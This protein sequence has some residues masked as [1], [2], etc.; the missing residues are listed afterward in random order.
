MLTSLPSEFA[1]KA[2]DKDPLK[3]PKW[4]CY[5]KWLSELNVRST[6]FKGD[7]EGYYYPNTKSDATYDSNGKRIISLDDFYEYYTNYINPQPTQKQITMTKKDLT[8]GMLVEFRN[9]DVGMILNDV[10]T[11]QG[12]DYITDV[13]SLKDDLTHENSSPGRSNSWDVMKVSRPLTGNDLADVANWNKRELNNHVKWV[14]P[15]DVKEMTV[16]EISAALGYEVKIV[17]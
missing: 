3:N 2:P 14:R 10:I 8:T 15:A 1:I 9:G 16:A 6:A 13:H 5:I 12:T 7:C 17:K 11:G 4:V